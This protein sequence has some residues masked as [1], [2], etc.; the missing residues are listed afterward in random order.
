ML[1]IRTCPKVKNKVVGLKVII[2][3]I[4]ILPSFVSGTTSLLKLF[5]DNSICGDLIIYIRHYK[6]IGRSFKQP[7]KFVSICT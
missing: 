4:F 7:M 6:N 5:Y 1:I 3:F 2:S